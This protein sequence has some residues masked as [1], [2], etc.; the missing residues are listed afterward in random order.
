MSDYAVSKLPTTENKKRV[1]ISVGKT[2]LLSKPGMV[3]D[4][5]KEVRN[6]RQPCFYERICVQ[7]LQRAIG[8][9]RESSFSSYHRRPLDY[10]ESERD[11]LYL[12]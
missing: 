4:A 8:N 11:C 2:E 9:Y 12:P 6:Q 3:V 1:L 5:L 7:P 10:D